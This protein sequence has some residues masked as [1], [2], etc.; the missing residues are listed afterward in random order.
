MGNRGDSTEK[1]PLRVGQLLLDRYQ[2]TDRLEAGG[3]SVVYL[4]DDLRLSRPVCVKVFHHITQK[5][6]VY[7][8]TYEHFVQEAFALSKL[9]HPNTLRIYDF[10]HLDGAEESPFQVCEY[11]SGGTLAELVRK[12]HGLSC[13]ETAE[14]IGGLA[15]AL[16]EAHG[17]GIIHR[18]I[19]PRNILFG[20]AGGTRSPKLAD[21]GIAKTLEMEHTQL[22]HQAGDTQVVAGGKVLL[23]S[24]HWAAPEQLI[25]DPVGPATDIY[26]LALLACYTLTGKCPFTEESAREGYYERK[27]GP[28]RVIDLLA[29]SGLPSTAIDLLAQAVRV[30]PKERPQNVAEFGERFAFEAV[31]KGNAETTAIEVPPHKQRTDPSMAVPPLRLS[32][33]AEPQVVLN[34]NTHFVPAGDQMADLTCGSARIRLTLMPITS[35]QTSVHIRGLNCFVSKDGGRP[36]MGTQLSQSGTVELVA[37]NQRLLCRFELLYGQASDDVNLFPIGSQYVAVGK[38]ECALAVAL[39]LGPGSD[40]F[41]VYTP[42]SDR[43]RRTEEMRSQG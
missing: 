25:A 6:G 16:A 39:D 18:D 8:A 27:H 19:K 9:T 15:G 5:E 23:F 10:G 38:A 21:F 40:L 24:P 1:N 4:A 11:M 36:T 42:S 3:T 22:T 33:S 35:R 7:R 14:I 37:N 12:N 17:V 2:I 32:P 26:S 30:D 41:F 13:Q 34:R 20:A 28:K 29:R 43:T 31:G